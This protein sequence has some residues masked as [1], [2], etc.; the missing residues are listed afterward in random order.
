MQKNV[1]TEENPEHE[2]CENSLNKKQ[3][4]ISSKNMNSENDIHCCRTPFPTNHKDGTVS[5]ISCK[6]RVYNGKLWSCPY[7]N[8]EQDMVNIVRK[9]NIPTIVCESCS[10]ES[11]YSEFIKKD[12]LFI[13]TNEEQLKKNQNNNITIVTRHQSN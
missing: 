5:C 2:R 12:K 8:A 11:T 9:D 6:T 4:N 7:C 3:S 13:I 10:K 1:K